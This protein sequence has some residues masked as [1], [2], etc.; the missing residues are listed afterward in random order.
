MQSEY[1]NP[2]FIN[3]IH[4]AARVQSIAERFGRRGAAADIGAIRSRI[5]IPSTRQLAARLFRCS[6]SLNPTNDFRRA[7]GARLVTR[8]YVLERAAGR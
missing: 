5:S 6:V 8:R 7:D 4:V 2:D 3:K 1:T